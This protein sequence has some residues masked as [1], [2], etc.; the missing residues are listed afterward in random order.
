MIMPRMTHSPNR[1]AAVATAKAMMRM[2]K[3]YM[4]VP[5]ILTPDVPATM[6]ANT[7]AVGVGPGPV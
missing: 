5:P 7:P 3:S 4:S 6:T 2:P 1:L